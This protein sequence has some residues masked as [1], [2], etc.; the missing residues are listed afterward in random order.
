MRARTIDEELLMAHMELLSNPT[1][2]F[3]TFTS[4]VEQREVAMPF[5]RLSLATQRMRMNEP[6]RKPLHRIRRS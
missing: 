4:G 2:T 5:A 6:H 1:I 3:Y